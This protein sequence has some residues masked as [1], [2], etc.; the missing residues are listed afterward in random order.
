MR[1]E[2][3]KDGRKLAYEMIDRYD[4]KTKLTSMMRTTAWPASAVLQMICDGS[5]AKRG[6]V[7]QETDVPADAFIRGMQQRGIELAF[8]EG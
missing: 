7:L 6:G 8:K 3:E 2:A 4:R 5:I 1:I